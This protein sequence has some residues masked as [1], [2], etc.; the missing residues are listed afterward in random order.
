MIIMLLI[1][2]TMEYDKQIQDFKQDF[3]INEASLEGSG[4]LRKYE[5]TEEWLKHIELFKD[6]STCPKDTV[7]TSQYI[8]IRKYDNK[9]I[10]VIQIRHSFNDLIEKYAGHVGYSICP[11]ERK[12]GYGSLML[13]LALPICKELGINK[14]LITCVEGNLGSRGV[15][16]NNGGKYE[17]TVYWKERDEY[18]ERYWIDL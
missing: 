17:S 10:G 11:S 1:E 5:T 2:P 16:E 9:M 14:V 15:I 13:K 4:S 6:S 8:F 3:I 12:K 18:L 7:P